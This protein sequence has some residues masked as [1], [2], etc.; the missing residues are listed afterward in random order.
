MSSLK[1]TPDE[2]ITSSYSAGKET[3]E[4]LFI[5]CLTQMQHPRLEAKN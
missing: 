2:I 4:F 1:I 5:D 3:N